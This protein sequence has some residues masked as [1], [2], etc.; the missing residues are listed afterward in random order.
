[1]ANSKCMKKIESQP[2]QNPDESPKAENFLYEERVLIF[3]PEHYKSKE[4]NVVYKNRPL[5]NPFVHMGKIRAA[6]K[7]ATRSKRNSAQKDSAYDQADTVMAEP[8]PVPLVKDLAP[9]KGIGSGAGKK[10]AWTDED[11]HKLKDGMNRYGEN[12]DLISE[13]VGRSVNGCK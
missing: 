9:K 13:Y 3:C 7:C 4:S 1:M 12:W 10:D 5:K 6:P 8:Q 11:C 2:V